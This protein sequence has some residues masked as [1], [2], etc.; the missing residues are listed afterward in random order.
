M[1]QGMCITS[2]RKLTSIPL[3]G[4][5]SPESHPLVILVWFSSM[6]AALVLLIIE[7]HQ[8]PKT[9][10]PNVLLC[11]HFSLERAQSHGPPGA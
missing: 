1:R 3:A 2:S 11:A 8:K 5:V 7:M 4:L 6:G 9:G 10:Q